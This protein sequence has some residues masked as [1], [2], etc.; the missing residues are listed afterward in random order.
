M[1]ELTAQQAIQAKIDRCRRLS[2]EG[3]DPVTTA[4]LLIHMLDLEK[5][6]RDLPK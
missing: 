6:Q 5:Q 4:R 3:A 2:L 1:I